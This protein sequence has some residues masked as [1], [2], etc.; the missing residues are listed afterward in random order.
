MPFL[1]V[2]LAWALW[3]RRVP[4]LTWAIVVALQTVLLAGGLVALRTGEAQ[5]TESKVVG[6]AAIAHHE[7]AARQFVWVAALTLAFR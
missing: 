7:A 3:V 2:S 1:A 6:E 4:R 5:R